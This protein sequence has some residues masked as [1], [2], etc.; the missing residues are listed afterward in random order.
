MSQD[1]VVKNS[2]FAAIVITVAAL[3]QSCANAPALDAKPD[4]PAAAA[5]APALARLKGPPVAPVKIV[6]ETFFGQSVP[7]PYRYMEDVKNPE[8]VA[9]M[10]AQGEH[11]RSVLDKI[12]GRAKMAARIAELSDSGIAISGVQITG[13]STSSRVFYYK[14][15]PGE[16]MR[17]L[18]VRDG[19]AGVERLLFDAQSLSIADPQSNAAPKRWAL[20]FYRASPDGAHVV[21][22]VAAGGSEETSLRIIE[23]AGAKQTST[24]IDRIGFAE[25][26]AW[27]ADSKSFFYNRL[28]AQKSG[29]AKNR[30]L[31]SVAFRHVLGRSAAQDEAIFGP[32]AAANVTF[33][34]IDIPHVQP[35]A[36]GRYLVGKIEHGDLREISL[37]V[38]EVSQLP[39]PI[40]WRKAVEPKDGVTAYAPAAGALYLLSH[41]DAPRNKIMRANLAKPDFAS[42]TTVVPHGDTVISEMAL[43]QDALYIRELVSGV[44]DRLQRW[45]FSSNSLG[46]VRLPAF[47]LTIRQMITDPQRPGALLRLESWTESPQYVS[48][49][50][51]TGNLADTRLLP[52]SKVDFEGITEVH[53]TVTAKDGAKVPLSL[54]YKK[55]TS[56]NAYNPTLMRAYG[57]YGFTQSPSF[58]PTS[59]AWLERGGILATCHVRGGGEFGVE[60]HRAGQKL[61]KPNS[62]RDLIACGEYMIQRK[63][64][65]KELL[66][67]QGG[68]AGG[69][70]VGRAMTER[71][72]LFAAVVPS[73]GML[74]AM[75]AEFT[76]NGP[77]NI[78][79]FGSVKTEDGFKG[80]LEM[81]SLHHV[82]EGTNYPAV[83][84]MHGVNDPRVEVWHSAKMAARLQAVSD[85]NKNAKPVLLRLDYDAGHGVGS[86]KSQRNAELADIYS[87]LL[88]QFQDPE[89]QPK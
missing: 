56:L 62:W 63:F 81:S 74:D 79:E 37:Y 13:G 51:R 85:A 10:R 38:G 75:R 58:S 70:T 59:M 73:V 35:T 89:F 6:T 88:W 55:G 21:V 86:T 82:K 71:P 44:D 36:D 23:V 24:M 9:Y 3:L 7:D 30:Y 61:N 32:G 60:W 17:K 20:D 46:F 66:A 39:G 78:P 54:I 77:P 2:V 57:A 26:L 47:D 18:Y 5:P 29:D 33:A 42:A 28:P 22:G 11:T 64:T 68:S 76:P 12:P 67:I 65:R 48:V 40:T 84:L 27:A 53:F 45:N 50:A 41:K 80:L 15:A 19:F 87:F 4:A 49:E 16:T 31:N 83:L 8:V 52:K 69:I 34:D 43:A 72:D 1:I 25:G 14:I